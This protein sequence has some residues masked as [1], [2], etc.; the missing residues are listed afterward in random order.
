MAAKGLSGKDR[1]RARF[2][3]E[4]D[5][6]VGAIHAAV[7]LLRDVGLPSVPDDD[8]DEASGQLGEAVDDL[9]RHAHSICG[10]AGTLGIEPA[11]E[12]ADIL[13][14]VALH[15][16]EEGMLADPVAW[17]LIARAVGALVACGAAC[18]SGG[19]GSAPALVEALMELRADF[20][21]RFIPP[22]D[23]ADDL[24]EVARMLR[25]SDEEMEAFG[26][27]TKSGQLSAVSRQLNGDISAPLAGELPEPS[28][29]DDESEDAARL[30]LSVGEG[31]PPSM[32]Q[33]APASI[34]VIAAGPDED[35]HGSV[36]DAA[37]LGTSATE[38]NDS[39]IDAED[40]GAPDTQENSPLPHVG[41]D[42]APRPSPV[43]PRPH[44]P[45]IESGVGGEGVPRVVVIFC[46]SGLRMLESVPPAL[47]TLEGDRWDVAAMRVV[48]RAF[49]TIKGDGRQIGFDAPAALSEAA[50]DIFDAIFD[51]RERETGAAYGVPV[52]ALPLLRQAHDD[53]AALFADPARLAR[54][55]TDRLPELLQA[56]LDVAGLV[57]GPSSLPPRREPLAAEQRRRRLL[58]MFLVEARRLVDTLHGYAG[59]L[60]ADPADVGALLGATRAL[61]TLKGNAASM[62]VGA[63]TDLTDG[64]ETLLEWM[65][66]HAEPV[67]PTQLHALDDLEGALRHALDALDHGEAPDAA[68]ITP[69]LTALD[70]ARVC[71]D[72][73]AVRLQPVAATDSASAPP[74]REVRESMPRFGD[75]RL[76]ISASSGA[77]SPPMHTGKTP[78][79]PAKHGAPDHPSAATMEQDTGAVTRGRSKGR[80][81]RPTDA[82]ASLTENIASVDLDD[83]GHAVD[84]FGRLVTAR[85]MITRGVDELQRPVTESARNS[86]RLRGVVDKLAAEFELV[87]RERRA[88]AQ[89]DG[90]DALE[91]ETFDSYT[92]LLLELGEIMADG[93]E[94]TARMGDGVR[95][96]TL[97]CDN[98]QDT[99]TGLQQSLLGFRL[100]PLGTVE[101]RLDQVVTSTARA[102]GKE[103]SWELRGGTVAVDKAVLDAVQ[104]PL[105]H[106]LRNA[107]DHGLE[108]ATERVA[109]GKSPSGMIV[110]EASYGVNSV[111][112]RVSDDGRGIDLDALAETAVRR[113][114]VSAGDAA[115][116]SAEDKLDL[117]WRPGFS[118]AAMITDISGRGVGLDIV[119]DAL[120]RIRGSVT[121]RSVVGQGTTFTLNVPLSLSVVRT[122]LLRDGD[123]MVAAPIAHIEAIHQ[124][125]LRDVTML[126]D[127]TVA[128]V[129]TPAGVGTV[130]L[131]DESLACPATLLERLTG[132]NI[133]VLE[134]RVGGDRTVGFVIDDV[135]GEEDTLVKTLPRYL[136]DH[137]AFLGCSVA[138]DGRPYAI[139]DLR[140]LAERGSIAR[141]TSMT[142]GASAPAPRTKPLAL[143]VDDSLF[144][145]R[146][147]AEIY[148]GVG[149]R[150]ETAEDGEDALTAIARLGLPDLLSVDMEM[151]RMNGLE[152]LAMV[153]QLPGGRDV[154]AFMVTTR[155]QER[156]R[157]EAIK[158][159]VTRYIIKP[160][161]AD[162]LASAARLAVHAEAAARSSA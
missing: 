56:L 134:V 14:E 98:S 26:F 153:R 106:L 161:D 152:M 31:E 108:S 104:E 36:T 55:I 142:T 85:T 3:D 22:A 88:A 105:L 117:L 128:L 127:R 39:D 135:L 115:T 20:E 102:V 100:V 9:Y 93:D 73:P 150:V 111:T 32:L 110:V 66:L 92:Q 2:L 76:S 11:R 69:V 86:Q 13:A 120:E 141:P 34:D 107:I 162:E 23:G 101:P 10:A 97:V 47:T 118:T 154:P 6:R 103:V 58:P 83:I 1:Y 121:L 68:A 37:G 112:I 119:R 18:K 79:I 70:S 67:A 40:S 43:A 78:A 50:E 84:L 96:T 125:H 52:E 33:L 147:L 94:I 71:A 41:S 139:V 12:A 126:G 51:A 7:A 116:L 89:R 45:H 77:S 90:W 130:P 4:L 136:R 25:L 137:A 28:N 99:M 143:V 30:S 8:E 16:N 132:D 42:V 29:L 72:S 160:F 159:G 129:N 74:A 64:G 113:G 61:H 124:V 53:L 80:T 17:D 109:R 46:E 148:E 24:A 95:R 38:A 44:L 123:A 59:V 54:T 122:L 156:H 157:Q 87:R 158:A 138:G 49:H 65:T 19:D 27:P 57:G 60:R 5:D 62:A 91:L 21:R 114:M 15:L 146:A 63:I 35:A 82:R 144:M 81:R 48:R 75:L 155:G 131:L 151:P 145:R 133:T 140:R 149:F